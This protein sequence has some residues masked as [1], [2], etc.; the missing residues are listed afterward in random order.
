M[1]IYKLDSRTEE[2]I[3]NAIPP[4]FQNIPSDLL[5]IK[6]NDNQQLPFATV[7]DA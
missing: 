2:T 1:Q 3:I 7:T 6:K 4:R 5:M